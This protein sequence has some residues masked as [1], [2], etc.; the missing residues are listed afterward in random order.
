MYR[1]GKWLKCK[2]ELNS[3]QHL[4]SVSEKF[5]QGLQYFSEMKFMTTGTTSFGFLSPT[6]TESLGP[7]TT[8]KYNKE[9]FYYSLTRDAMSDC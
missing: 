8:D 5:L 6:W 1:L 3:S 2:Q 4:F 7:L 9:N